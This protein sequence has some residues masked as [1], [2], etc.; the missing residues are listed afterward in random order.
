MANGGEPRKKRKDLRQSSRSKKRQRNKNK[1]F[2]RK[3]TLTLKKKCTPKNSGNAVETKLAPSP[4]CRLHTVH[5]FSLLFSR[6]VA[7]HGFGS[8]RPQV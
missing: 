4:I 7:R 3:R 8:S 5:V 6:D 2:D 1:E